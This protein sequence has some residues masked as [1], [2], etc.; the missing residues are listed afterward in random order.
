MKI[1]D[2]NDICY[3]WL[4]FIRTNSLQDC[5]LASVLWYPDRTW[6]CARKYLC[7]CC[8]YG[9]MWSP[10]IRCNPIC[11]KIGTRAYRNTEYISSFGWSVNVICC[12]LFRWVLIGCTRSFWYKIRR[13]IVRSCKP[14]TNR[15]SFEFMIFKVIH[16]LYFHGPLTRYVK[17]RFVRAPGMPGTFSP[18]LTSKENAS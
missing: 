1:T 9:C 16:C 6:P 3:L 11:Y 2:I 12:N 17:L 13:V 8:R 4:H 10:C 18:P 5:C 7:Q 14:L 15:I